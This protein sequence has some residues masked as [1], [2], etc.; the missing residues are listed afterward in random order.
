MPKDLIVYSDPVK[1]SNDKSAK[2]ARLDF[3]ALGTDTESAASSSTNNTDNRVST[4]RG[5]IAKPERKANKYL[6]RV[7][8]DEDEL[9]HYPLEEYNSEYVSN[10]DKENYSSAITDFCENITDEQKKIY[11]DMAVLLK[12]VKAETGKRNQFVTI[13]INRM[14]GNTLPDGV[15]ITKLP[16]INYA[17]GDETDD[18]IP[19]N[20]ANDYSDDDKEALPPEDSL[21][22]VLS[23][24]KV[25]TLPSGKNVGDIYTEK[26]S[27]NAHTVKNKKRLTAIKKAILRYGSLRIIDLSTHMKK[28]F[29]EN[30]KK[31][32]KKDYE[33][34]LRVLKMTGKESSFVLKV[35]DI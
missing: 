12:N 35:E 32:I 29:C 15:K 8:H 6:N 26:I 16:P 3:N 10:E 4:N 30:D 34:M 31:F 20:E 21:Y 11:D 25:W 14:K 23:S 9:L 33:S 1:N 19:S 22:F 24:S 27:E 17:E 2:K 13:E 18:G 5:R 7:K 28:W